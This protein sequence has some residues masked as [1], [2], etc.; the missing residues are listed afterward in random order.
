[1]RT[2]TVYGR[3]RPC[4]DHLDPTWPRGCDVGNMSLLSKI[5]PDTEH[6]PRKPYGFGWSFNP[7]EFRFPILKFGCPK[8]KR[9]SP[10]A[11]EAGNPRSLGFLTGSLKWLGHFTRHWLSKK[12]LFWTRLF[13]CLKYTGVPRRFGRATVSHQAP[14]C[15]RELEWLL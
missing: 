5:F 10:G 6:L 15:H 8:R 1:M 11:G 2:V 9:S 4:T 12:L 7:S 14:N 13:C 3:V